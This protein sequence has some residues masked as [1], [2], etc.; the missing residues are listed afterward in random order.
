MK[1]SNADTSF[2]L[3]GFGEQRKNYNILFEAILSF[4]Q[5]DFQFGIWLRLSLM[6]Y[7]EFYPY[8][9]SYLY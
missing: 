8:L 6:C 4:S 1:K 2:L 5:K 3:P 7:Y 9:V